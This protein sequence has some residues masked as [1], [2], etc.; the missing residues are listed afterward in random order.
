MLVVIL[1]ETLTKVLQSEEFHNSLWPGAISCS[2]HADYRNPYIFV[3]SLLLQVFLMDFDGKD[4]WTCLVII[5]SPGSN[6]LLYLD[7]GA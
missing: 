3:D 2:G 4:G 6:H 7:I 1:Y 5:V